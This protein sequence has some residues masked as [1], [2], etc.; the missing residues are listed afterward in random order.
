M[1]LARD[2]S[3][4]LFAAAAGGTLQLAGY[5]LLAVALMMLDHHNSWLPRLRG[6]M[7]VVVEPAWR[8]AGAPARWAGELR[9]NLTTRASLRDEN[10]KLREA[11]LLANVRIAHMQAL[12]RQNSQLKRLLDAAESL[13]MQ[14]QLARVIDIDLDPYRRRLVLNRGARQG[15]RVGQPVVDAH[16]VMGQVIEALPD[17]SVVMLITDPSAALPVIDARSGVRA[18]AFGTGT[19]AV[20]SLPSLPIN[21]DVRTG[22]QLLT[23]GLG[24]RFP[25]GFPVGTVTATA[26]NV[27]GNYLHADARPSARL[28][29]SDQVLLLRDLAEPV[30][31]PAPAE[32]AGPP[33]SLLGPGPAHAASAGAQR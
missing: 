10:S 1:A 32:Q 16:G 31:P 22:D 18:L 12:V 7:A 11:L 9:E 20:L 29:R 23:S 4:G 2:G 6:S 3:S 8:L 19:E 26:P 28:N 24:G 5:L 13:R 30:G 15:V 33:A 14:G 25:A 21:A 27:A 17:T